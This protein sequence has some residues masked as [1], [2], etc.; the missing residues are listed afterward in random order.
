MAAQKETKF[1]I[2]THYIKR[3]KPELS[4]SSW[5]LRITDHKEKPSPVFIIKER[6]SPDK[7]VDASPDTPVSRSI[8]KDRGVIY[9]QAQLR[10]LS[11][12]RV[13]SQRICNASG[14]PLE[15]HQFIHDKQFRGNLPLNDEAGY[16]FALIFKLQER[17]K[18]MDRVELIAR[19][20]DRFTKEEAAYWYSRITN[21][22]DVANRW[23]L[24]GMKVMLSGY[25]KDTNIEVMLEE[26]RK[27]Y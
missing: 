27:K 3:V 6:I 21:F 18:E 24:A 8:L 5:V 9:G 15:L 11:I 25:P 14:I 20:V 4:K 7:R 26:L 16:K 12:I 13:I 10:C 22:S 19:R 2:Q 17:L 1:E 23:A